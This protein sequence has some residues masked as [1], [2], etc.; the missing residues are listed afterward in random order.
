MNVGGAYVGVTDMDTIGA[1]TK[2]SLVLAE[3]EE[4]A[5][6]PR[7]AGSHTTLTK[8]SSRRRARSRRSQLAT[9]TKSSV[10]QRKIPR[11]YSQRPHQT[12]DAL[13]PGWACLLYPARWRVPI[14]VSVFLGS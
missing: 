7:S 11:A 12:S 14:R 2:F 5:R 6:A 1:A 13:R 10:C 4:D 9:R 3:N 8:V